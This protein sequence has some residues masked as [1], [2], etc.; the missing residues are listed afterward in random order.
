M[1]SHLKST[2]AH[3]PNE[4]IKKKITSSNED[5]TGFLNLTIDKAP[6]IPKDKAI[7][8]DITLVIEYVIIGNNNNVSEPE[9]VLTQV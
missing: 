1:I 2:A 9:K 7:L 8:P 4:I 6:I 3:M 5:L